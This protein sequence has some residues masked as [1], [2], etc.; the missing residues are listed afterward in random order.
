ML[1]VGTIRPRLASQAEGVMNYG[2]YIVIIWFNGIYAPVYPITSEP[3]CVLPVFQYIG[4]S[5]TK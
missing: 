1:N 2:P 3:P 4:R 5:L